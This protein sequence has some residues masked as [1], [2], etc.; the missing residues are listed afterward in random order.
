[1]S[2]RRPRIL[3]A[4]GAAGLLAL[5]GCGGSADGGGDRGRVDAIF[6][7]ASFAGP[8]QDVR[9][10][11]AKV[12]SITDVAL[13]G[14]HRARVTMEVDR[15]F[16]PFRRDA[17]C[18]VL[19]QSLIGE[20]F[21]DC[22]PGTP[23]SP[24]L[25]AAEGQDAPTLAL[26]RTR[27]PVDLDLVVA[28]LGQPANV[29][30]QLLLNEIGAGTTARGPAL[31]AAIRR[32]NPALE[33]I[34]ATLDVLERDKASLARA[35]DASGTV[36]AELDRG[37]GDLTRFVRDGGRLLAT[38]GAYR[39]D[40]DATL[41]RIAPALRQLRPALQD[42]ATT[43]R[44]A[45]PAV[46][47]LRAAAPDVTGLVRQAGPLADAARPT[48][49]RLGRASTVSV[50]RLRRALEPLTT[51]ADA[52]T[53]LAPSVPLAKDV[54]QSLRDS[55]GAEQLGLFAYNGALS[56][57]RFD[58]TSHLIPVQIIPMLCSVVS[59]VPVPSCEGRFADETAGKVAKT[60]TQRRALERRA[61][62][63]DPPALTGRTR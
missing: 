37:R 32:A 43:S 62:R 47:D 63:Q 58:E 20:R 36:L 29:R 39:D 52:V 60:A 49:R 24:A 18:S 61:L 10:A 28:M 51:L 42:L 40:L 15:R 17:T 31:A 23:A 35:V 14:D 2:A 46:A 57:S 38:T 53:G 12:G 21:V 27:S 6:A 9:I 1:V 30:L 41:A 19:P 33:Q 16:L 44:E 34:K 48:L 7:N 59:Q 45:T 25:E 4:L 56:T 11:G 5:A 55:G 13:T 50:P 54:A 3:V 8:G 26:G 22:D